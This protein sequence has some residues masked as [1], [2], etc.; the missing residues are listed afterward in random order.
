MEGLNTGNVQELSTLIDNLLAAAERLQ[1]YRAAILV[2]EQRQIDRTHGLV[3]SKSTKFVTKFV[4]KFM[5]N[6][7][8]YSNF[9][10]SSF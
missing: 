5:T 6:A 1:Y 9:W 4:T 10:K 2:Q 8:F 3:Q 7:K